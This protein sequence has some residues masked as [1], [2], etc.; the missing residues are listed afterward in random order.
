MRVVL[1]I[2]SFPFIALI[3]L[4]QWIISPMLGPKCRFTPTCSQYS[5]QAFKKYGVFKGLWLTI[6]RIGRCHPWGGHGYDPVP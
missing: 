5:L 2:L 1:R 3:K 4:Y 6:R